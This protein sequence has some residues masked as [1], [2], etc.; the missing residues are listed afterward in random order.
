MA[1]PM[2]LMMKG[3]LVYNHELTTNYNIVSGR[4]GRE[5]NVMQAM[6][7]NTLTKTQDN[8][9]L[10]FFDFGQDKRKSNRQG[11][12]LIFNKIRTQGN[13]DYIKNQNSISF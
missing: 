11:F 5:A 7:G 13:P 2:W 8:Q 3:Q 1:K 6:A 12:V 10:R 4:Y 9:L